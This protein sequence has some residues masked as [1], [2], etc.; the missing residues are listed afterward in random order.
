VPPYDDEPYLRALYDACETFVE[1]S[2][3]IP[4]DVSA[5]TVRRYMIE[6]GVHEPDSYDTRAGDDEASEGDGDGTDAADP[7]P[8]ASADP[9]PEATAADD[10]AGD[11]GDDGP[12]AAGPTADGEAGAGAGARDGDDPAREDASDGDGESSRE[13]AVIPD[14][15]VVADGVGLPEGVALADVADAVVESTA[16]YQV[17][18]RLGLDHAETRRLLEDLDL[19][20]LLHHRL[21][22]HERVA[23]SYE[24]V[25]ARIRRCAPGA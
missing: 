9:D 24:Q 11:G 4:M 8:G 3:R 16:E 13:P 17:S 25:A 19:L 14:E 6:A 5:E 1:M 20:D 7:D 18:R 10:P 12:G 23:T 15:R 21:A 2:D 22:D